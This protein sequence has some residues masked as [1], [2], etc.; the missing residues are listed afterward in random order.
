MART[1]IGLSRTGDRVQVTLDRAQLNYT[2]DTVEVDLSTLPG[3]TLMERGEAIV[4][5]LR[6]QDPVRQGIES[7]LNLPPDAEPTPLYFHVRSETADAVAWEQM[8][9]KPLGFWALDQRCP[10]GRIAERVAT[11]RGRGFAPPLRVVAVLS[12]AGRD[13]RPQLD[14]LRTSIANAKLPVRLHVI[15]GDDEL[16]AA[17]DGPGE[18]AEL[19]TGTSPELCRQIAAARPH[20][21]HL[22]CHGMTVAGERTL[23]FASVGDVD[24]EVDEAGSISVPIKDL[25]R[26][27]QTCDPWLVVLAACQTADASAGERAFAHD[28]VSLGVTATIG[29]RRLVDLKDTDSFCRELY[30]E[31]LAAVRTAVDPAHP[32]EQTIEWACVLTGP[33]KVMGGPDPSKV[34]SWLDPVLYVQSEDLRVYTQT[35]VMSAEDYS[36]LQGRLDQLRSYL[37]TADPQSTPPPVIADVR[38]KIADGEA[39]LGQAGV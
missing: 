27:L 33:R 21:L 13:P 14:A 36:N 32:G 34:D 30:P 1:V 16:V 9:A 22:L 17:V 35:S 38:D 31:V 5:L 18:T 23:A 20:V 8:F 28:L 24:A 19:T 4:A 29:M 26:E 12:A 25:A 6:Q 10:M 2:Y 15:A 39:I 7:F 3:T 11:V 37:A